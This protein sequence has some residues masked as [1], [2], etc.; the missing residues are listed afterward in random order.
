[1][2]LFKIE[3]YKI[4]NRK[5]VKVCMTLVLLIQVLLL[6][7]TGLFDGGTYINGTRYTGLA[8]IRMDKQIT[9]EF[10]GEFTDEK[11]RAI[12]D[13]Y[14]FVRKNE[15]SRT[16]EYNF[17]N[18]FLLDHGMTDGSRKSWEEYQNAT[19][20]IPLADT[21]M[22]Q[23]ARR[24][25]VTVKLLYTKGWQVYETLGSIGAILTCLFLIVTLTPVFA[26]EYTLKT[27]NI[28]LTTVRGKKED[29]TAKIA[30]SYVFALGSL[31]LILLFTFLLCGFVFGF[32]GLDALAGTVTG[33]WFAIG[34]VEL[35]NVCTITIGQF[36]LLM[37]LLAVLA[38]VMLTAFILFASATA[39]TSFIAL[40]Y[41]I[42]F[43]IFPGA[44][45]GFLQM[46]GLLKVSEQTIRIA[47]KII[48]VLQSMPMYLC[49]NGI[50][51]T[52]IYWDLWI[53]K[54]VVFVLI[55]APSLFFARRRYRDHQVV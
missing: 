43:F 55:C 8:A 52:C 39:R 9:E 13:K 29:I 7:V 11:A 40:V 33:M 30:A 31:A 35:F 15:E 50:V 21:A 44:G 47:G 20:L 12:V 4:V 48:D 37:T 1:M 36:F 46:C 16:E 14:G 24:E 38:V 54:A 32:G 6:C 19:K 26:E 17:L 41:T 25:G 28:L 22:G 27:A 51:A 23:L 49:M 10:E 45:F 42:V 3:L 18:R 34:E 53:Y 2:R 5:I